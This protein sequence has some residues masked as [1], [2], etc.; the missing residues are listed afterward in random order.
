V[1]YLSTAEA[2]DEVSRRYPAVELL[3]NNLGIYEPKAFE[4]ISDDS[5]R[6]LFEVNV[7]SGVRLAR[8]QTL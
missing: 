6:R 4:D 5:W 3:V 1:G 8:L 7:L 2:A